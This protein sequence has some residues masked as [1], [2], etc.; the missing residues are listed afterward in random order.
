MGVLKRSLSADSVEKVA[1][2][3]GLR[4]NLCIGQ[5]GSTQHDGA[6]IE[7]AGTTVFTRS[8]L[9]ITSPPITF[10]VAF[11]SAENPTFSTESTQN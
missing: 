6:V 3:S 9:K 11:R 1:H 8:T 10:C 4:Q 5:Q 7:W 2:L